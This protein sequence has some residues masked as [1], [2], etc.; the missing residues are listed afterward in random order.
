MDNS[1]I[2]KTPEVLK[3]IRECGHTAL[4]LPPYSPMLN[5]IEECW[6]KIKA[7]VRKTPLKK[8]ELVSDLIEEAAR[9]IS[10]KSCKGWI[11]HSQQFFGK[12]MKRHNTNK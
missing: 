3:V 12:C 5:P 7:E 9:N 11:R 4:F 1:A 10:K 6:A 2:H 8:N